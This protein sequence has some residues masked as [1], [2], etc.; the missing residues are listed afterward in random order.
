[1]IARLICCFPL[2][3]CLGLAGVQSHSKAPAK[4]QKV[5]AAAKLVAPVV[6]VNVIVDGEPVAFDGT[7]PQV[8]QG[9][10]MVPLRGVFEKIGCLVEYD[11]AN[12]II[13]AHYQN[14]S[15]EIRMGNKIANKNGAEIMMEVPAMVTDGHALVPLRFLAESIGA[16]V[17]FEQT[18][19]T[20]TITTDKG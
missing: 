11:A 4:G 2:L 8:F 17:E 6:P 9:R 13:T 10:I 18:T 20:V 15:V 5:V 1:M 7:Q 16:K 12:H 14:E 3:L 19:N